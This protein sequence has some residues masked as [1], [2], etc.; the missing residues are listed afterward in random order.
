[1]NS[2]LEWPRGSERGTFTGEHGHLPPLAPENACTG[3]SQWIIESWHVPDIGEP[4][5]VKAASFFTC[6][7]FDEMIKTLRQY[8]VQKLGPYR[9]ETYRMRNLDT[10]EIVMADIL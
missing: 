3:W 8:K 9:D 1:M 10:D 5:W 4:G 7:T 2:H 6:A